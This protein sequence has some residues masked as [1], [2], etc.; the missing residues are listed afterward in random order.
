MLIWIV[1]SRGL[2]GTAFVKLLKER[3]AAF[4]ATSRKECD[5]TSWEAVQHKGKK[6]V[7]THIV[8]CAAYTQVDL[9]ER[10]EEAAS[11]VNATGP[12]HLALIANELHARLIH[13]STD[14]LFD[15]AMRRPYRE[16]DACAPLSGYGRSKWE[17]EKR[18]EKTANKWCIVRT[19]WLFGPGGGNFLSS[20]LSRMQ[21][22]EEV[23]VVSDQVNRPT[24]AF[25]LAEAL[26]SLLDAQ[27]IYHFANGHPMT[28]FEMARDLFEEGNKRGMRLNCKRVLPISMALFE[29]AAR[30]PPYSA[31]D[32][33][34]VTE[35]L[36]KPPRSWKEI[37]EEYLC[38]QNACL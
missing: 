17:G 29:Q 16:M 36:G 33:S 37:L 9:A 8:N 2:L 28:R 23:Q 19:S 13:L 24:F 25:D 20:V 1:G 26:F 32:T 35:F 14:Y 27:G 38:S 5:I 4:S 11:L 6:I 30:R 22:E 34:T 18:I 3:G 31:L 12:Y 10:E 21:R 15:G 7:P